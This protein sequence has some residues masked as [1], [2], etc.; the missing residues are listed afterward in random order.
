MAMFLPPN[1][2]AVLQPMDQNP[3]RLVK[4]AYRSKL[5]CS[6]VAQENIPLENVL[7]S[8]TLQDTILLLKSVWDE[9]PQS[10]L[11]KAWKIFK[12]WDEN[13]YDD[14]ENIPLSE[15]IEPNDIYN[16]T[17]NEV[18]LL[19]SKV[20]ADVELSFDEI[21][22]WD[23]D[24]AVEEDEGVEMYEVDDELEIIE[25]P[26]VTYTE[27]IESINILIK[28]H[29]NNNNAIQV[30]NLLEMRANIFKEFVNREKKTI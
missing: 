27:A 18:Q 8:H 23:E 19:L 16:S 24:E 1:V 6:I 7:K 21:E 4:L 17:L 3:I 11:I 22:K 2:T 26:K 29:Q 14:E 9:L 15:L 10:V 20:G 28:W 25:K 12:N 5:L 30:A 13:E